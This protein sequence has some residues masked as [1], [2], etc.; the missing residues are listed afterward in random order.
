[1]YNAV[2]KNENGDQFYF[3]V[4]GKNVFDMDVG[5]GLATNM[6]LSQGFS[7]TGESVDSVTVSSR[8][9]NVKGVFFDDVDN[10]KKT[11]RKVATPFTKGKLFFENKYYT[12]VYVKNSPS[13]SPKKGDGRFTMQFIAPFPFFYLINEQSA[14]I[15]YVKPTF[16][17]PVNYAYPHK[18]GEKTDAKYVNVVNPGDVP[19]PFSLYLKANGVSVNPVVS[20]VKTREFLKVNG[21][22]SDGATLKVTRNADGVL[23][24]TLTSGGVEEDVL[25][26]IDE[27]SSLFEFATG[28]N[29]I[30]AD[31]D[32]GGGNLSA[33]VTF[34]PAVVAVYED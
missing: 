30:F 18:F 1:M 11:L 34:N 5:E 24:A 2:F 14:L 6:S 27:E 8:T 21:T 4:S 7:Q 22:L 29:L 9:I 32:G 33:R 25:S 13:F 23:N 20:N 10:Q 16:S 12:N 3:G 26:W 31:D 15:G 19:V 28:D 17:F